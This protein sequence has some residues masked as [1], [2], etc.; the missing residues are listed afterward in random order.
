MTVELVELQRYQ[1][2]DALATARK[3]M[4]LAALAMRAIGTFGES[5]YGSIKPDL[6]VLGNDPVIALLLGLRAGLDGLKVLIVPDALGQQDA[7]SNSYAQVSV[8][9][10]NCWT[11][12]IAN[13]LSRWI[14]G[15]FRDATLARA[16]TALTAACSETKQV[17]VL[18]GSM[19]QSES[20]HCRGLPGHE[21]FFPIRGEVDS[22]GLHPLWPMIQRSIPC[23]K[24]NGR[25]LEFIAARKVCLT[26]HPSRHIQ[27]LPGMTRAGLFRDGRDHRGQWE[28]ERFEDFLH[29][30]R[31]ELR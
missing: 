2:R 20:G 8:S 12:D 22:S 15:S 31:V 26:T 16:F 6:L 11:P 5:L 19:I 18:T 9:E 7:P 17:R 13:E 1:V 14:G 23:L 28:R 4:G 29:A 24:F 25:E 27:L 10:A 21:L 30:R 3:D